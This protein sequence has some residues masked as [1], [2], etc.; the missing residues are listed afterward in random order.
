M[1]F[2][3]NIKA[4]THMS[5]DQA[6]SFYYTTILDLTSYISYFLFSLGLATYVWPKEI[7]KK[8]VLKAVVVFIASYAFTIVFSSLL[9][10]IGNAIRGP[11]FL[12]SL[13]FTLSLPLITLAFSFIFFKGRKLH[14]LIKTLVLISTIVII[15][16]LS[17]NFGFLIGT[18]SNNLFFLV[19]LARSFPFIV[20]PGVCYLIRRIDIN[21]YRNLS[22]EMVIIISV[23]SA[24]LIFAG[25]YEHS[26]GIQEIAVNVLLVL[27]D[28]VLLFILSFSYYAT[29]KNIEH[30]HRIT[31]LEV[32]RTLEDA[33]KMSIEIDQTNR[34][35]LEK[36]RH[37]IKNQ[38][39]YLKVMLQQG[40]NDE[41]KKYIDEYLNT[42]K[43]VLNSFSCSNNV[44]N[45]IINLE[46][47]KA[48]IKKIKIDV[49]VV[50]PPLLPFKDNDLV[51]L[52]TNM[53]DNAIENYYSEVKETIVVRIIKQNDF[54]RFIVSNPVNMEKINPRNN[55]TT[56]RKAGRGH[57]Y[58]TKIIKNIAN[59]YNGYVDFNIEDNRFIC[60]AVLNLNVKEN[61]DA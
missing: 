25:V 56:T 50:V 61:Q 49:K 52:L 11:Q 42:S 1:D 54:I 29:Y 37:D 48:K 32:Q 27:L 12:T 55:L 58:G 60:D 53:I 14:W 23:L 4:Q 44:I 21:H 43:E 5:F 45:S 57:G 28:V 35:E 7:N 17:K 19:V 16:A 15:E 8:G 59:A 3:Y 51:S 40:Q 39:S 33:E 36:I 24:L 41:A 46:L 30:R 6:F 9:F 34:E 20:F 22:I 47:T 2:C 10:A 31:N 38:F 26:S 18:V 13:I